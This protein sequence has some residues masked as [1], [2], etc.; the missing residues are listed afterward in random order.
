MSSLEVNSTNSFVDILAN[1]T[2][3]IIKLTLLAML[4]GHQQGRQVDVNLRRVEAA[5]SAIDSLA[6]EYAGLP[7]LIARQE[8]DLD[9]WRQRMAVAEDDLAELDDAITAARRAAQAAAE[10]LARI[11]AQMRLSASTLSLEERVERARAEASRLLAGCGDEARQALAQSDEELR[12]RMQEA[13]RRTQSLAEE[14]E[15]LAAEVRARSE[16]LAAE[17]AALRAEQQRI[18]AEERARLRRVEVRQPTERAYGS[19]PVI[20]ECYRASDGSQRARLLT[21]ANYRREEGRWV[22]IQE[23]VTVER[24][25]RHPDFQPLL[26][27]RPGE[28]RF[29][30]AIVRPN[31]FEALRALR[32]VFENAGWRVEWDPLELERPI[33]WGAGA[34]PA[35]AAPASGAP[36]SGEGAAGR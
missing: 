19:R 13:E 24:L 36:A 22:P 21:S 35:P 1:T 4:L 10:E 32:P 20:V 16:R 29:L 2:G 27:T 30:Y 15:R 5:R 28:G 18:E 9:T 12:R 34:A 26:A 31:A 7:D 3:M 25:A 11:E 8:R 17:E 33:S 23:G 6:V 14:S